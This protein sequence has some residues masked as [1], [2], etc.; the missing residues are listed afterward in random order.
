M[1]RRDEDGQHG[2]EPDRVEGCPHPAETESLFGQDA[3][4]AAFHQA[5][6]SGRLHHAW[7]ITGAQGVGKAT[8]AYRLARALLT[9]ETAPARFD[10]D[11]DC[12]V[13]GRIRAGSETRLIVLRRGLDRPGRADAR[14][15]TV[16]AAEEARGLNRAL[17]FRV[18]DGGRRVVIVDSIDECNTQ[19]ANA[20]LKNVEEPPA[21]THFLM[22]SHRPAGLLPTIRSRCR[23]LALAPLG[24]ADLGAALGALGSRVDDGALAG[25]AALAGGS[26][27]AAWKLVDAEGLALYATLCGL[28]APHGDGADL[29]RVIALA[30]TVGGRDRV[31]RFRLVLDLGVTLIVRLARAAAEETAPPPAVPAEATLLDAAARAGPPHARR[32]AAAAAAMAAEGQKAR[33][34]NLDPARTVIDTWARLGPRSS[35]EAPAA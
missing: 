19:A 17:S 12:P 27:A 20:L 29:R 34:A 31:E 9:H 10:M 25:L 14:L 5:W 22:L 16:I 30:D 24:P 23:K 3:A 11:P 6:T 35:G 18:P 15:R 1:S 28:I 21:R 7:L 8:L 2:P 32:L 26:V 33:D 4:V 13:T